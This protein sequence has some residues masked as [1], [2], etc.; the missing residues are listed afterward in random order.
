[1]LWTY[2]YIEKD[3]WYKLTE[4]LSIDEETVYFYLDGKFITSIPA[5]SSAGTVVRSAYAAIASGAAGSGGE[6]KFYIDN[7]LISSA[8]DVPYVH[9]V[10]ESGADGRTRLCVYG[11]D[12]ES[13]ISVFSAAY[14][15]DFDGIRDISCKTLSIPYRSS[16][17]KYFDE[18]K[19]GVYEKVLIWEKESIS[20]F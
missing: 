6:T 9:A 3:R 19:C 10:R 2:A 20:P 11:A 7:V 13:E 5:S 17:C 4:Y 12:K 8:E 14:S 15:D 18:Y 1:M 16:L